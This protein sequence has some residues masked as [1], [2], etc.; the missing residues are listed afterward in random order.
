[1]NILV[2][3]V[4]PLQQGRKL[5]LKSPKRLLEE[6]IHFLIY[7][8]LYYKDRKHKFKEFKKCLAKLNF[9]F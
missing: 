8:V 9:L 1:M 3:E 7:I 5:R 4:Y 6:I 2:L